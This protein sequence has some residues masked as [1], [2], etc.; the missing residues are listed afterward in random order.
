M[1]RAFCGLAVLFLVMLLLYSLVYN[2]LTADRITMA[3]KKIELPSSPVISNLKKVD[4]ASSSEKTESFT[5]LQKRPAA[6]LAELV[7]R[8]K[9]EGS[10][11]ALSKTIGPRQLGGSGNLATR[12]F[13]VAELQAL[14]FRESAKT[15]IRQGFNAFGRFTENIIAVIPTDI[16]DAPIV[17]L[18]A[19]FDT[20]SNVEGAVDNASGVASLLEMARVIRESGQTFDF[21]I[22]LCF[23]SA[24]ENG[25][26]GAYRY[27]NQLDR[28]SLM[29]HAAFINM[30][31]TGH[32]LNDSEQALVVCTKGSPN[33]SD[34]AEP[35]LVSKSAEKAFLIL[36][37]KAHE[38][39]SP[40][41]TGKHDI[42]PFVAGGIRSATFSWREIDFSRAADNS[43]GLAP[44]TTMHTKEDSF[45]N[46]DVDSVFIMTR[47]IAASFSIVGDY[48]ALK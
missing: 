3:P 46:I 36:S 30:D 26:L 25:Y 48:V 32:G 21:E 44:P 8:E 14:G 4:V 28:V 24:E 19:H 38:L 29:R 7:S 17:A 41:N 23:F 9:L 22:R 20:V 43:Y 35:N 13:I 34:P 40:M 39:Y 27:L 11:Y 1:R 2:D 31:M 45:E 33:G 18:G 6:E 16:S 47:L 42:V 5:L 10:L 15:L 12:R 37:L